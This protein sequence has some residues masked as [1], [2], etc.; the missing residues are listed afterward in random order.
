MGYDT[1]TNL[2]TGHI[3]PEAELIALSVCA[4]S[5]RERGP[6]TEKKNLKIKRKSLL[7]LKSGSPKEETA[8]VTANT[9]EAQGNQRADPAA[10]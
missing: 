7:S 4:M 9:P 2:A 3:G 10:R 8:I 5:Y 6:L 1:G